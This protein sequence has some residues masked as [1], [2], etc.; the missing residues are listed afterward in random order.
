MGYK[1]PLS[2]IETH[3]RISNS[4]IL[5]HK[6]G[7]CYKVQKLPSTHIHTIALVLIAVKAQFIRTRQLRRTPYRNR[8]KCEIENKCPI[9]HPN[10]LNGDP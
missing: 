6:T 9:T 4:M 3:A 1:L 8:I 5:A 2:R 10:E 7:N